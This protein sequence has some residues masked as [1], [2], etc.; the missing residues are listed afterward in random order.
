MLHDA[1][2]HQ[3]LT[4]IAAVHHQ[5]VGQ[6]LHNGALR[7]PKTL[8]GVPSSG[9][10]HKGSMLVHGH[11]NVVGQGDVIDLDTTP[12]PPG[13]LGRVKN[14]SYHS[15]KILEIL[16]DIHSKTSHTRNITAPRYTKS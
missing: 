13:L 2:S 16:K 3:L 7:L 14:L 5:G 9:M 8:H 12:P 6:P 1:Y 15:P 4:I 11:G 10:G